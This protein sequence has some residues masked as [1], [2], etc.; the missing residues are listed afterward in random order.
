MGT[1]GIEMRK[2]LNGKIWDTSKATALCEIWTGTGIKDFKHMDC[3]LFVTPRSKSFFLAGY[4]G[5]LTVFSKTL[6]DGSISGSE[7]I[8]PIDADMARRLCEEQDVDVETMEK[9][10]N[11]EE[12]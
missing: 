3:T 5:G 11:I 1:G 7:G 10:F 2:V 12:A 4:G 6:A 8:V 9:Y